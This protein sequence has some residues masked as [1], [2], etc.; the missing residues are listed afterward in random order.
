MIFSVFHQGFLS[1][2]VEGY[3]NPYGTIDFLR[4]ETLWYVAAGTPWSQ[5]N[6]IN[7]L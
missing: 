1:R 4:T 6:I 7:F 2:Q 5:P 3:N